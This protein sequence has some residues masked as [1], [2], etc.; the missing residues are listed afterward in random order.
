MPVAK[1]TAPVEDPLGMTADLDIDLHKVVRC[2][3]EITVLI[4]LVATGELRCDFLKELYIFLASR[5]WPV[6]CVAGSS[7]QGLEKNLLQLEFVSYAIRRFQAAGIDVGKPDQVAEGIEVAKRLLQPRV[8]HCK[9]YCIT[10]HLVYVNSISWILFS[11][12]N[13]EFNDRPCSTKP[14]D[15]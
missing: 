6:M 15:I 14:V 13:V 8:F 7:Q 5:G 1:R 3:R 10:R 11:T 12:Q 9:A 2:H 4:H